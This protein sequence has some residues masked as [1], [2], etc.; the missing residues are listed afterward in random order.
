MN[1]ESEESEEYGQL[2]S[3]LTDSPK[4]D[5]ARKGLLVLEV[6][7]RILNFL[8]EHCKGIVYDKKLDRDPLMLE[9]IHPE[10]PGPTVKEGEWSLAVDVARESPY[11]APRVVDLQRHITDTRRRPHPDFSNPGRKKF[12]W[13]RTIVSAI[14]EVY[15]NIAEWGITNRLIDELIELHKTQ[16]MGRYT[17]QEFDIEYLQSICKMQILLDYRLIELCQRELGFVFPS[18]PALRS[19]FERSSSGLRLRDDLDKKDE[20]LWLVRELMKKDTDCPKNVVAAELSRL[21]QTDK[22]YKARISPMAARFIADLGLSYELRA[23]SRMLCPSLFSGPAPLSGEQVDTSQ[24][25]VGEQL[26]GLHELKMCTSVSHSGDKFLRLGESGDPA[27][28]PYPIN[29][30]RTKE[31]VETMQKTERQLDLL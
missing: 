16:P 7:H 11:A 29:K 30:K 12:F 1:L 20:L 13:D 27:R 15:E 5:N 21:V 6:Q 31:H 23:Q 8:V 24:T 10:L 14:D 9:P 26:R 4:A 17:T 22:N 25:W 2:E 18:S 19:M 3:I 28:L